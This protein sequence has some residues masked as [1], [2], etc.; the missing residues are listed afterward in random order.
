M[1]LQF[2]V[3][4]S[5]S[6]PPRPSTSKESDANNQEDGLEI[7]TFMNID[8]ENVLNDTYE[9]DVNNLSMFS[10]CSDFETSVNNDI[11]N[12]NDVTMDSQRIRRKKQSYNLFESPNEESDPDDPNDLDFN[13]TLDINQTNMSD[14]D[15]EDVDDNVANVQ[16]QNIGEHSE[17]EARNNT[18][19]NNVNK[20][21]KK[22]N[23]DNWKKIVNFKK[24][25]KGEA[26]I[27]YRRS[28]AGKVAQ[29]IQR[30]AKRMGQSCVSRFCVRSTKRACQSIKEQER[31]NLFKNFWKTLN[32]DQRKVYIVSLV[33]RKEVLRK[34]TVS[35]ASRRSDTLQYHLV[36][37]GKK[38]QVCQQMF[39]NTLGIKKWTVRY[40]IYGDKNTPIASVNENKIAPSSTV[41]RK[42]KKGS[43]IKKEQHENL[44][45][46]FF[47]TSKV[48]KPLL[49]IYFKE[50]LPGDLF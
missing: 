41:T 11:L 10:K 7:S 29:D 3:C 2:D 1:V 35:E 46:F 36:V 16:E 13:P 20:L 34:R 43:K 28:G 48:T 14:E 40:W 9:I 32:W 27:G 12:E 37:N 18:P 17:N 5:G 6:P 4:V 26:Y 39:L 45:S 23:K 19:I 47:K 24:R 38:V 21:R 49:S 15:P 42:S 50:T 31:E 30:E 33:E 25:E 8:L 22:G 44:V